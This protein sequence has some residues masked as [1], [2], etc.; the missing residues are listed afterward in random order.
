MTAVLAVA[1]A[2]VFGAADFLGGMATKRA[3]ALHVT[4]T[5]QIAGALLLIVAL[6]VLPGSPTWP[7][8][9]WGLASGV[10]AG[11]AL[12]LFYAAMARGTMSI[13]SPI[14]AATS[15][16]VP[17]VVGLGLG[18]RPPVTAIAGVACAVL[19][20][21]LVGREPGS[22]ADGRDAGGEDAGMPASDGREGGATALRTVPPAAE[23]GRAPMGSLAAAIL[24]GV[25]FGVF[26]VLLSRAGEGG[27][28]W[29]LLGARVGSLSLYGLLALG[30]LP[31]TAA[32]L[33]L[34]RGAMAATV[35]AGVLDMTANAL[36]LVAVTGGLLSL[37]AVLASLYPVSTILLARFLLG[38]RLAGVQ[39]LGVGAALLAVV[40]IA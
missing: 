27:G 14:T 12:M 26:F 15:A 33:A 6:T 10:A 8:L 28:L 7:G 38:E 2:M 22:A 32:G 29:P 9:V 17:F 16:V 13:V 11:A 23:N 24:A 39:W 36:Y 37:V 20:V 19:A 31:G 40:L 25:G 34:P 30:V 35:G 21:V 3:P 18:E 4:V 1:S 5:S